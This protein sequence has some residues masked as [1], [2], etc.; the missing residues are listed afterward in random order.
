MKGLITSLVLRYQM[1]ADSL[2]YT[3]FL[4]KNA[5]EYIDSLCLSY[6]H[7]SYS[8]LLDYNLAKLM[9]LKDN[10]ASK[11]L[12]GFSYNENINYA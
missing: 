1:K 11:K 4:K 8:H 3:H 2:I 6:R 12:L 9:V 7:Y 5:P 10:G